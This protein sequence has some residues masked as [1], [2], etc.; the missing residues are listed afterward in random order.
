MDKEKPHYYGILPAEV[1]YNEHLTPHGKILYSELT[2][3]CNKEG[4]CWAS[5]SYFADLY[6]TRPET[7]SVWIRDL[8]KEGFIKTQLTKVQT[9]TRRKIW[10]LALTKNRKSALTKNN[11]HNTTSSFNKDTKVSCRD[12]SLSP[13]IRK[14]FG[15][16][17]IKIWNDLPYTRTHTSESIIEEVESYMK[18]LINGTFFKGKE[19]NK[20]YFKRNKISTKEHKY[21]YTRAELMQG[22]RNV[23][24]YSKEGYTKI[25]TKDL[26]TLIYN[27]RTGTSV[28]LSVIKEPPIS[29][30]EGR[31]IPDQTPHLTRI[32][33][34]K[35]DYPKDKIP[36][37]DKVRLIEGI[38]TLVAYQDT[39]NIRTDRMERLFDTPDLLCQTY[40]KWME[41]QDWIVN[42]TLGMIK[43]DGKMFYRFVK[44]MEED[45]NG[46]KLVTKGQANEC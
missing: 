28:F 21:K 31:D 32:F 44:E 30:M 16:R 11:E 27:P 1:R 10:I 15:Y 18:Q 45:C 41:G 4:Y 43:S 19:I 2:A 42:I 5:N 22:V 40:I 20:G 6:N 26:P 3:L 14:S 39:I 17:C 36:S 13:S 23:A 37:N 38:K 46:L 9:G 29:L 33:T 35:M 25:R 12:N 7:V 34:A 8:V 24:L